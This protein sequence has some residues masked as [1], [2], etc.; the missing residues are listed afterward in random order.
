MYRPQLSQLGFQFED[1]D[2]NAVALLGNALH[3]GEAS[4][5]K[6]KKLFGDITRNSVEVAIR[7]AIKYFNEKLTK[8]TQWDPDSV[9]DH[10]AAA[11]QIRAMMIEL[12]ETADMIQP[13]LIEEEF[14]TPVKVAGGTLL[15]IGKPDCFD[16]RNIIWD[17][18]S[19]EKKPIA[20]AQFGGYIIT[21]EWHG[22]KVS[23]CHM[24]YIQR[25][26][27]SKISEQ[28][29]AEVTALN[30]NLCLELAWI[31][32][33]EIKA[34]WNIFEET[35]QPSAF[36]ANPKSK[37]CTKT[38]CQAYASEWCCVGKEEE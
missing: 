19:A 25:L 33:R 16:I 4:L 31:A 9:P 34:H 35:Q 30:M 12:A 22:Y 11:D 36:P 23:G 3:E 15:L 38:H 17:H 32:L 37:L 21:L 10:H 8:Q 6:S 5:L 27:I 18:K 2:Q 29:P 1:R 7:D 14:E 24:N 28:P 13:V 20:L 26:R